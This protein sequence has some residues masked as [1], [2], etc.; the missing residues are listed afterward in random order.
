[1]TSFD[2]V[3]TAITGISAIPVT[4]FDDR[5]EVDEDGLRTVLRRIEADVVVA[6]GNTSEQFSLAADEWERVSELTVEESGGTPVLVGVGGDLRTAARQAARARELGAVGVMVHYPTQPLVS[7]AGLLDY[8]TRLADATGGAVVP[9]VRGAGLSP[10]VL[11]GVAHLPSV[12]A[13]KYA[14]P[15]QMAFADFAQ[16]YGD[17]LVPVCGLA[18]MWA[19]F[20]WLAGARGFTSGL[21]NV[22]PKL[23]RAMLEALR[24]ADYDRAMAL[25]RIVAPFERLRARHR[26][27]NNVP[28]VK[29]AMESLGL[30]ASGAVRPPLSPLSREDRAELERILPALEPYLPKPAESPR[31]KNR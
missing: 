18:E 15:D 6:C 23:S 8:Y 10:A 30:I 11:D 25:W 24:R 5:G 28:V 7:D 14:V 22:A 27:G 21:V 1:M 13:I 29:E 17:A 26:N 2:K 16:R 31:M 19:P 3:S 4:P 12:V 20:F 9:Y